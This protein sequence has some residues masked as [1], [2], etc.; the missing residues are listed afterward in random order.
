M[1]VVKAINTLPVKENLANKSKREKASYSETSS[2]STFTA[3]SPLQTSALAQDYAPKVPLRYAKALYDY[4]AREEDEIC[5]EEEDIVSIIKSGLGWSYGDNNGNVGYFPESYVRI[6]SDEEASMEGLVNGQ[7]D[8]EQPKIAETRGWYNK[9]KLIGR[10]EKNKKVMS[11][12]NSN[13]F[14]PSPTA[15]LSSTDTATVLVMSEQAEVESPSFN[16]VEKS[17]SFP[18]STELKSATALEST[19][20]TESIKRKITKGITSSHNRKSSD[21]RGSKGHMAIMVTPQVLKPRWTEIMGGAEEVAK[22]GLTKKEIKRQ[23][24]IYEVLSTERDYI[25]DLDIIIEVT[26]FENCFTYFA[27][28]KL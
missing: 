16:S 8:D 17:S 7:L 3:T 13:S 19:S 20:A 4:A 15:V 11:I 22:L 27:I 2:P 25:E 10:Y 1:T 5:L 21:S 9:Y 18:T 26:D 23:E 6:L 12:P 28:F 24:V 14:N